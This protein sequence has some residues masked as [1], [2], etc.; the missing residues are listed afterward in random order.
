MVLARGIFLDLG[1]DT[2]VRICV[3]SIFVD[4]FTAFAVR[5]II[6]D[7]DSFESWPSQPKH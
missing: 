4:E 2:D 1:N 3:C 5:V 6:T 7:K